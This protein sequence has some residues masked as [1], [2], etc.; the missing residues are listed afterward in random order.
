MTAD[1]GLHCEQW[2]NRL[3]DNHSDSGSSCT[4]QAAWGGSS[5][6]SISTG[7]GHQVNM[8]NDHEYYS[9]F[10]RRSSRNKEGA[11]HRPDEEADSKPSHTVF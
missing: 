10:T 2:V 9:I 7:D 6:L 11:I 4:E 1:I 5:S 8:N 3:R